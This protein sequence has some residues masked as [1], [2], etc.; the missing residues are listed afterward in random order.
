MAINEYNVP[1][2][3]PETFPQQA[4]HYR[5]VSLKIAAGD[6][7][8]VYIEYQVVNHNF[9]IILSDPADTTIDVSNSMPDFIHAV[10]ASN[11]L[12]ATDLN[13]G[14]DAFFVIEG[15]ITAIR[16]TNTSGSS[17]TAEINMG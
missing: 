14:S 9:S 10:P 13:S 7:A 8:I 1:V 2:M 4:Y 5:V 3:T 16:L 11:G 6:T 15:P 12:W 17:V